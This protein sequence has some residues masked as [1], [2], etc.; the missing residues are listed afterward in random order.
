MSSMDEPV[1]TTASVEEVMAAIEAIDLAAPWPEVAPRLRLALPR[2][3]PL[4]VDAAEL[5]AREFSPGIRVVLGLDI[6][7]AMLFVAHEQLAAWGVTLDDAFEQALDNVRA[8]VAARRQFALIC[9]R[10]AD[11]PTVAF[12]SR[13][14]W[15]SSLLLL[16]DELVRVLGE[17]NG[18]VLAPM[19]DILI[20]LPLDVERD[21]ARYLLDEFAAV[22]MN[23]L[24]LPPFALVDGHLSHAVGVPRSLRRR[25]PVN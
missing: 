11:V 2:R 1:V 16:P 9:E 20:C 22:D 5:P 21:F 8:R 7:P 4:P 13:E 6:G 18:L 19:R 3:R 23:A 14:G 24:D 17:R 25:P 15:A 10:I 12:Q